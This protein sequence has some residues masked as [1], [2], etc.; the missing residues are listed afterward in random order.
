MTLVENNQSR[1][2]V[3]IEL[4]SPSGQKIIPMAQGCPVVLFEDPMT[5]MELRGF[6]GSLAKLAFIAPRE[7]LIQRMDQGVCQQEE[8]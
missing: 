6:N 7:I 1:S 3:E 5:T 4:A 8:S 2:R